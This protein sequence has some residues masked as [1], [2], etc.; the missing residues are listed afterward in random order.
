MFTCKCMELDFFPVSDKNPKVLLDIKNVKT[1][2][3]CA[4]KMAQWLRALTALPK[5]LCSV[6]STHMASHICLMPSSGVQ[7]YMQTSTHIHK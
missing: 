4:G 1:K 7:M 3:M 2:T 6:P 5:G